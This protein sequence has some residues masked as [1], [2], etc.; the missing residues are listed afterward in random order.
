MARRGLRAPKLASEFRSARITTYEAVQDAVRFLL[1]FYHRFP[2]YAQRPLYLAGESYGGHYVPTL[3]HAILKYNARPEAGKYGVVAI[4]L[5]ARPCT[6][7]VSVLWRLLR[8]HACG[9]GGSRR[10]VAAEKKRRSEVNV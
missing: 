10:S 1:R 9:D 3:A 4:Q 6:L 8:G 2:R 7:G 5:K